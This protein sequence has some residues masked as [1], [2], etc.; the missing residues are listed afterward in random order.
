MTA[1]ELRANCVRTACVR[2]GE[3]IVGERHNKQRLERQTDRLYDIQRYIF[4]IFKKLNV[5]KI[6]VYLGYP[7]LYIA[8]V[9]NAMNNFTTFLM[10]HF[11]NKSNTCNGTLLIL[12]ILFYYNKSAVTAIMERFCCP[13]SSFI[14]FI[15]FLANLLVKFLN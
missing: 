4:V 13:F 8:D 15:I 7:M 1:C 5:T 2:D 3:C 9:H 14:Y 10:K 11:I 12:V 6:S